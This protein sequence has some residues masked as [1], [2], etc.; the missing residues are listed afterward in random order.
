[1]A[2]NLLSLIA[3]IALIAILLQLLI[4]LLHI[5]FFAVREESPQSSTNFFA[6]HRLSSPHLAGIN[7]LNH[8]LVLLLP[9]LPEG[10]ALQAVPCIIDAST[11][12]SHSATPRF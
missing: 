9:P 12:S 8:A 11:K 3:L 2:L 7:P 1:V 5:G 4:I 10:N 6:R